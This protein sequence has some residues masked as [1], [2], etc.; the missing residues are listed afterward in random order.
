MSAEQ[1]VTGVIYRLLRKMKNKLAPSFKKKKKKENTSFY[2]DKRADLEL[3]IW[4]ISNSC[5]TLAGVSGDT[6]GRHAL[7]FQKC[8]K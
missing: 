2:S 1:P 5:I 6:E 8:Y 3:V 4:Q 7:T